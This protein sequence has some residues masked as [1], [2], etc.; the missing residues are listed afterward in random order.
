M[1]AL[2]R[3]ENKTNLDKDNGIGFNTAMGKL[4]AIVHMEVS[5]RQLEKQTGAQEKRRK[6]YIKNKLFLW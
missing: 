6:K 1:T 3:V 2:I 5:R 4:L